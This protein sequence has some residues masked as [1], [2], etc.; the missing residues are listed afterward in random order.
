MKNALLFTLFFSSLLNAQTYYKKISDK[1]IN[2]E[3]QTVAKNFIQDFL[4]KCED[5]NY[6]KFE[7]YNIV[8]KFEI[9]LDEK[10]E[11]ICNKNDEE[12]GKIELLS[13]DSAHINKYSINRDPY[14][15]FIFNAKTEKNPD[16]K[17]LSVWI[18]QD[19]N[20][21][22]GMVITKEKPFNPNKRD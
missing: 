17:F 7:H 5:K 21:I 18:H 10:L 19:K 12:V 4:K 15:L 14:E 6:T 8:K 13:F 11:N 3:R 22:R 1:D 20:Y 2:T 16:L 9:F